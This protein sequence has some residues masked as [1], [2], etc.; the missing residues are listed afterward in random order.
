MLGKVKISVVSSWYN[1]SKDNK[2]AGKQE[3]IYMCVQTTGST[4]IR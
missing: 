3:A 1:N 4:K 2:L